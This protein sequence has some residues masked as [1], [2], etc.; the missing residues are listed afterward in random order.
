MASVWGRRMTA[1]V[2]ALVGLNC[3][4]VGQTTAPE[5][6]KV[7]SARRLLAEGKTELAGRALAE[8][9]RDNPQDG[10]AHLLLGEMLND[11]NRSGDAIEPLTKAVRLLPDSAVAH[12]A[13]GEAF[14][15]LNSL[16]PARAE[17]EKAVQLEPNMPLAHL[18]LGMVLAQTDELSAAAK[19]LDFAIAK[20]GATPDAARAHYLRAKVYTDLSQVERA[21]V[22]L[23]VAVR[24][25]PDFAEAWSDLGEARRTLLDDAG[26]LA[27]FERAVTLS[28]SDPVALSRLG[29]ELY[30]QG[31]FKQAVVELEKAALINP[32]DQTTLNALQAA[33]RANGQTAR[34]NQVKANLVAV[35]KE[36]D[37]STQAEFG[38]LRLNE[39]GAEL[40]KAGNLRGAL[41]KYRLGLQ[42]D[43][44]DVGIRVNLAVTLL[45]LGQ[46][47]EGL[48]ELA[49][50]MRRRPGDPTLKAA[51]DD[52]LR[53]APPGSWQ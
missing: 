46:W 20:L 51:W 52:A 31:K 6:A 48:S 3:A 40:E 22:E 34:A 15:N 42:L 16:S 9:I 25:A 4:V 18:N 13:L 50:S 28:P 30:H 1:L 44:E 33:L 21:S 23:H 45:R 32:K 27:A 43:P 12:N 38:A 53:Q 17:F 37:Q 41:D 8:A 5:S 11:D 10:P 19:H 35:L 39:E 36:R 26:A 29:N 14:N 2:A 49:E 7:R 24:I 47:K